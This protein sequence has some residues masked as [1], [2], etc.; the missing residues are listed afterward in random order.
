MSLVRYA[1]L[2]ASSHNTQPW[3]FEIDADRLAPG[4]RVVIERPATLD[5]SWP[6]G[7]APDADY[8]YGQTQLSLGVYEAKGTQ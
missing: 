6:N 7:L 2:A 1:T 4:A 3:I 5:W 8:R